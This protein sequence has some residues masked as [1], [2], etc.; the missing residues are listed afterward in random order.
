MNQK[1]VDN[2]MIAVIF[3]AIAAMIAITVKTHENM[4]A[5]RE[6]SKIHKCEFDGCPY[7]GMKYQMASRVNS[8]F[9]TEG[10]DTY[11]LDDLH[12][13][14]PAASYEQL[15]SMLFTNTTNAK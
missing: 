13:K 15:D 11:C 5:S 10:T 14:F 2:V 3:V 4:K 6:A 1:K 9:N 8:T 12:L 7:N